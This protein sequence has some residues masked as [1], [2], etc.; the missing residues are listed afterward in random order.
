[1]KWG[2]LRP[3]RAPPLYTDLNSFQ[4]APPGTSVTSMPF[5][6]SSSRI[7]SASAKFLALLGTAPPAPGRRSQDRPLR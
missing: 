3:G 4:T 7:R 2:A 1:M 5:A 6:F